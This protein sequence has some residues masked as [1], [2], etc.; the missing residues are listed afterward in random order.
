MLAMLIFLS[1]DGHLLIVSM[2]SQSFMTM[3]IALNGGGID[4]IKIAKWGG[5][6][7]SL[8]LLLSLP[9]VATL[10]I[11]NMALGILTRTAPQLNLFG[12]GFPVTLSMGFLILALA[13]P[14]MLQ[15][16]DQL[17]QKGFNSARELVSASH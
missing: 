15:P 13:L 2:V 10:L 4:V 11:I 1:L 14:S 3:P 8:G 6:V 7:F 12:I 17:F 16:I 9:C 5:E